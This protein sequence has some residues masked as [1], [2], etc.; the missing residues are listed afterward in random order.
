VLVCK[1]WWG[2][3]EVTEL[4]DK[5]TNHLWTL[6]KMYPDKNWDWRG[7]AQNPNFSLGMISLLPEVDNNYSFAASK[8][9][10]WDYI[11]SHPEIEWNKDGVSIN[12]N[13]TV[14]I[15]ENNLDWGWDWLSLISNSKIGFKGVRKLISRELLNEAF[16]YVPVEE[17][18]DWES[19]NGREIS[20]EAMMALSSNSS[21]TVAIILERVDLDWDMYNVSKNG[22]CITWDVVLQYPN[23]LTAKLKW[24]WS[25]ISL[26]PN[27]TWDIIQKYSNEERTG[28]KGLKWDKRA[29]S[30]HPNITWSIISSNLDWGWDWKR[31][32]INPNITWEIARDNLHLLSETM[33]GVTFKTVLDNPNVEWD[34]ADISRLP[35]LTWKNV[36]DNINRNWDWKWLSYNSFG[37]TKQQ[38]HNRI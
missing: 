32:N 1:E 18:I 30:S 34:Q 11:Q 14:D 16:G 15:V 20:S 23:G 38:L 7:V 28:I 13:I 33:K 10:T 25:G 4:A 31:V 9:V 22:W 5:F 3:L 17:I 24:N 6:I 19:L 37:K 27:I 21:L 12:P 26:N 35:S 2:I 29:L 36:R 8:A